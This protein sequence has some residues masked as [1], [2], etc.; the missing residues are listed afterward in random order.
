M[1][2]RS[3]RITLYDKKREKEINS[4]NIKLYNKY[5]MDMSIRELSE[6]S[7][8][9]YKTDIYAWFIYVLDF[10]QNQCVI[11]FEEDDITE[12]IYYCKQQGNH[13][14]RIKRRM[15]SLSTFYKFLRKKKMI[16]ENPMEFLDRPKHGV[17]IVVQTFLTEEQVK[18]MKEKL[19]ENGDLQLEVYGLFSLST[20]ARVTAISNT[21]WE[22]IDF[23]NRVVNDVLEKEGKMVTLYFSEEVKTKLLELQKYRKQKGINDNGFVFVANHKDGYSNVA[24][25]TLA[26]WATKIGQM[27]GIKDGIH[28]HDFRHSNA[29]LLRNKGMKLEDISTLLNHAGVDVTRKYYIKEDIKKISQNKDKFEI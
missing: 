27:I 9:G 22:Q 15:S 23:E 18:T 13:T 24:S 1:E 28:P 20:I 21:R 16:K 12:F 25:G 14:E 3:K 7:I 17:P 4:D 10:Q 19:K 11:D 2:K 26:D 5:E 29:T 8:Y 6:K